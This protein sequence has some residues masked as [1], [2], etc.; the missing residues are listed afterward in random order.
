VSFALDDYRAPMRADVREA[1]DDAFIVRCE[2][3]RF[4]ETALE[5]RQRSDAPWSLY[6][7]SI[8]D[9]L[10]AASKDAVLLDLEVLR[11][12]V[13]ARGERRCATNV[14]VDLEIGRGHPANLVF[15]HRHARPAISHGQLQRKTTCQVR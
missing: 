13:D 7:C 4:V 12:G 2:Y 8:S 14:L 6:P 5:Q 1:P 3:Q 10:P 11:I 9:P 15:E